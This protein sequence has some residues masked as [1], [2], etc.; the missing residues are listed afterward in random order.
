MAKKKKT[1][2]QTK[3]SH[4]GSQLSQE[5][6]ALIVSY[7]IADNCEN[8][9]KAL[10]K[11]G[12]SVNTAKYACT[13]IF[14]DDRVISEINRQ[15][16]PIVATNQITL[17]SEQN[18]LL[19]IADKAYEDGKYA[20]AVSA[21]CA[22]IKTI[23]G[24]QADRLP[25]ENL[26]GKMLDAKKAEDMRRIA[27]L[28]YSE[29]YLADGAVKQVESQ[30]KGDVNTLHNPE[31]QPEN[32][33]SVNSLHMDSAGNTDT[34]HGIPVEFQTDEEISQSNTHDPPGTPP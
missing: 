24:F 10:I 6:I 9:S 32:D 28:Y 27:D 12:Y 5:R 33:E 16:H 4:K 29:K 13:R 22:I 11:A 23:G 34:L 30:V 21:H 7:Y 3:P 1:T 25:D 2:S 31:N 20:A 14:N 15:L 18:K 17:I 19:Q 26:A 8:K